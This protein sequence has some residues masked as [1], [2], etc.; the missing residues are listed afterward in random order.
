MAPG[1]EGGKMVKTLTPHGMATSTPAHE[2]TSLQQ[3]PLNKC[4]KKK[5]A[6]S[7]HGSEGKTPTT[8]TV[9][10]R[11]R[12]CGRCGKWR[13]TVITRPDLPVSKKETGAVTNYGGLSNKRLCKCKTAKDQKNKKGLSP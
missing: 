12:R 2:G 7:P 13:V 5:K 6:A 9:V 3:G 10:S 11:C 1:R 8:A 4:E